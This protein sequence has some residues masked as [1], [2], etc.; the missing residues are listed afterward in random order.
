ML[1]PETKLLEWIQGKELVKVGQ[2]QESI[3]KIHKRV[4]SSTYSKQ[5][6]E[7][8]KKKKGIIELTNYKGDY[9]LVAKREFL[10]V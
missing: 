3:A 7:L 5:T 10:A 9:V 8:E 2:L 1:T 4:N 6:G